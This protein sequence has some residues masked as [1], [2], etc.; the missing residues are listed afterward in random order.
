M[1]TVAWVGA[2]IVLA[3]LI[4]L[5]VAG[6]SGA[7][8]ILVTAVALTAMIGLG[9]TM[10]GRHTPNVEP[11][12]TGPQRDGGSGHRPDS[13]DRSESGGGPESGEGDVADGA[14]R[15]DGAD[16]PTAEP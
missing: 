4:I 3:G 5:A 1:R 12:S 16:V 8:A 7:T 9:S 2:I 6:I 13:H 11:V 10:G 15:A 14:D